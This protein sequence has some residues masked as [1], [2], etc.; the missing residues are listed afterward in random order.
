MVYAIIRYKMFE[1]PIEII[2]LYD[3]YQEC[4]QQRKLI[5]QAMPCNDY[6]YELRGINSAKNPKVGDIIGEV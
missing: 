3:D 1:G 4:K 5:C 2:S 6:A